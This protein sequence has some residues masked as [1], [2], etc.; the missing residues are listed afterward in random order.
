MGSAEF[1]GH[2]GFIKHWNTLC[3]EKLLSAGPAGFGSHHW[4]SGPTSDMKS[5]MPATDDQLIVYK[6]VGAPA[7]LEG[8]PVKEQ[9]FRFDHHHLYAVDFYIF[10]DE[11]RE[12]VK[13]AL[14]KKF[15]TP[16]TY[17]E[18]VHSYSWKWPGKNEAIE[19]SYNETQKETT[20]TYSHGEH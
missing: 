8:V 16:L 14:V 9:D 20:V 11:N 10:G 4:G 7:P 15:G 19:M 1:E 5:V 17:D 2:S 6:P 3:V 18:A 12:L 13:T